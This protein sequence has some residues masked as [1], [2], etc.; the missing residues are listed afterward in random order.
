MIT[1]ALETVIEQRVEE[2]TK[3]NAID[4]NQVIE[5]IT[6]YRSVEEMHAI[7]DTF[8]Q[9]DRE[10]EFEILNNYYQHRIEND[11]SIIDKDSLDVETVDDCGLLEDCFNEYLDNCDLRDVAKDIIDRL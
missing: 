3:A 6:G 8:R 5:Y 1:K 9:K 10:G 7:F 11:D 2:K 4:L